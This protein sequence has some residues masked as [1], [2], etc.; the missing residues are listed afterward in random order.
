[1]SFSLTESVGALLV[2]MSV[3]NSGVK[4]MNWILMPNVFFDGLF[5]FTEQ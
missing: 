1:M 4:D 2:Q 3:L 5:I